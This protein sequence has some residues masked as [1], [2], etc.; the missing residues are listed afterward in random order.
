MKRLLILS[1][2][3][4]I[5]WRFYSAAASVSLGPGVTV[6]TIPEQAAVEPYVV[7][8]VDGYDIKALATFTVRGKVLSR[9][10]YSRGREADLSPLDL[11]LGWGRM[12]DEAVLEKIDISQ[13][14]RF[15]RWYVESFPIPRREIETH[16]ANM[17][18]IPQYD[19]VK[20]ML[21][22]V[23]EGEVVEL[24]GYLVEVNSTT[25]SW[26]WRSSLTRNDTGAGACEV[27]LVERVYIPSRD[28]AAK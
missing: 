4:L 25:D 23:K 7:H 13:S 22:G 19:Y 16:S 12:S 14:G 11:A 17:H 15:Y 27:I 9:K 21:D 28:A 2:L 26:Y 10:D 1:V 20:T 6:T 3:L 8:R 24:Q 5:I 18:L